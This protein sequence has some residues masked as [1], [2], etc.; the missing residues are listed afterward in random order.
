MQVILLEKIGKL[1]N[2]GDIVDIKRGYA[3]NYLIPTGKA[4]KATKENI[5][6]FE[7]M[8]SKLEEKQKAT[9]DEALAKKVLI[10][11]KEF[12]IKQ[13]SGIDGRLFGSVTTMDIVQILKDNDIIILKSSVRLPNGPL[14]NVGEYEIFVALHH[15]AIAKV[16]L[17]VLPLSE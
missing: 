4:K 17:K 2:L 13:K 15:D 1:G 8:K 9:L 11:Q 7:Q 12:V 3:R 6:D 5:H 14:K 10:E 16:K